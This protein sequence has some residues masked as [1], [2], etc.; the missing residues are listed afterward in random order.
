M[1]EHEEKEELRTVND[2]TE[3]DIIDEDEWLEED[4]SGEQPVEPAKNEPK[5]GTET[6]SKKPEYALGIA[7]MALGILSLLLFC[8]PVLGLVLATVAIILG[9]VAAA[10]D[11]G[12]KMG[13]SGIVMGSIGMLSY[14]I[15]ILFFGGV[16]SSVNQNRD[17]FS[18]T[19][20]R[21]TTDGSVLY[22]YS[23]GTFIDVEQ[24]G[25]FSDNF[26][27]GTYDILDYEDTGLNFSQLQKQYDT[28]YA[29]DIC[30]YVKQYVN[31]GEE[32]QNIA[33][34]MRY[35]YFIEKG[36]ESGEIVMSCPH[37]SS[38]YGSMY[39]MRE[40]SLAYP[41]IGNQYLADSGASSQVSTETEEQIT[42]EAETAEQINTESATEV[43]TEATTE[44]TTEAVVSTE[45]AGGNTAAPS[46]WGDV[47]DFFEN[48]KESWNDFSS[49]ASESW[50]DSQKEIS[51]AIEEASSAAGNLEDIAEEASSAMEEASSAMEDASSAIDELLT[52]TE[53]ASTEANDSDVTE[54]IQKWLERL[55]EK[56]QN[57][58]ASWTW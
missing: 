54:G 10:R 30:L 28:D 56:I 27:A 1:Q 11:N 33:N 20:W 41:T 38:Q 26:Y 25:V 52:T 8:I 43:T 14:L 37:D 32:R 46:I 51:S 48:S 49:S 18:G 55:V 31:N 23:D 39:P 50:E 40:T 42:T 9:I 7:A 53:A 44:V 45:E 57:W 5:T 15:I 16:L 3:E 47:E 58:I 22:L 36:Y 34:T 17:Y 12:K 4:V 21:N 13:V 6:D 35:L 24:E 2:S 19:A 29:Y